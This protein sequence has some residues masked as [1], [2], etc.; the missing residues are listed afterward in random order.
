MKNA[1]TYIIIMLFATILLAAC[2]PGET[3]HQSHNGETHSETEHSNDHSHDDHEHDRDSHDHGERVPNNG[4]VVRIV[5]PATSTT[6]AQGDEIIIE[7]ETENFPLGEDGNHWHLYVNDVSW[8]MILGAN[9][10]EVVRGLTPGE[11]KIAAYLSIYTHEEL[12]DGDS[13]TIIVT[14]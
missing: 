1:Y 14:E 13:I 7:I 9:Y 3:N 6:F 2:G 12:A 4:A 10:N 8:G 11:Y 5:D